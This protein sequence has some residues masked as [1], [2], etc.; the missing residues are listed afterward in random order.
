MPRREET[1]MA[2][3]VRAAGL[4]VLAASGAVAPA[5]WNE[6]GGM[7]CTGEALEEFTSCMGH[8]DLVTC[9][10]TKFER[11][12]IEKPEDSTLCPVSRNS[13]FRSISAH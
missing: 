5:A 10:T 9:D 3:V 6:T 1:G 12:D 7:A 11:C 8:C 4:L 13:M 2:A